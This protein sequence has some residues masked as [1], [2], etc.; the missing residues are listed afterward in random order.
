MKEF[1]IEVHEDGKVKT[2][3][4]GDTLDEAVEMFK[5][6]MQIRENAK[7][8]TGNDIGEKIANWAKSGEKLK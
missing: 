7:N 1:V 4:K 3:V 5:L 6:G 2:R 8:F